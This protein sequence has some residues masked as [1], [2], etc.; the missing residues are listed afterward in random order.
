MVNYRMI[1][2]MIIKMYN[3]LK[4]KSMK[5]NKNISMGIILVFCFALGIT[6]CKEDSDLELPRLFRPIN[7]NVETNKTVATITWA[8]VDD[9]VSYT[10]Q[11]STDSVN[12][13]ANIV[14]DTTL[15]ELSFVKELAGE[16]N[17]YARLYANASDAA[18]NSKYNS[19]SFKTPAENIFTGYGTDIN[20]GKL[21]SAYMTD[22]HTLTIKWVPAAN[23][24][25]LIL[26]SADEATRDSLVI[27]GS[28]ALAGEKVVSSLDNSKWSVKIYNNKILRGT[29]T[30][31]I[32]GDVIVA[33]TD[34][35]PTAIT[36]AIDGQ[37]LLLAKGALYQMGSATFRLGK[38]VKVRG[39]SANNRPVLAMTSGTPT[40]TSSMLGFVDGSLIDYVKFENIDFTG[41]CDNSNSATK[42]GYL[43]NNNVLTTVKNLTFTNCNLHNFGNTPMRVQASKNQVIDTLSFNGCT[44]F[45]VGFS[46]TYA[47]VNSN[48]ADFINNINFSY[49]TIYN[50]KGSLVLRQNQSFNAINITNCTINQGMQDTGSTRFLIDAN[51]ATVNG[52]GVTIK[53]CIL[54]QT[55]SVEKGAAGIRTTGTV[56]IS[57]TYCTKDYFDETLVGGAA[58]SVKDKMTLFSGNSTDLWNAPTTGD[59]TL[60]ASAFA[61][62][63]TVGDLRWY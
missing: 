26:T 49:C 24:T 4:E 16:T 23:V 41:Y 46:S 52:T 25:H 56:S 57:T 2:D 47:I 1:M 40:T 9:A 30:G 44:I 58:F 53:N 19:L 14:L 13:D 60:K 48:S 43:F 51:T 61:G 62:K 12:Y 35:L 54:G 55:G 38:N 37:V 36:N 11:L 3:T 29:T 50:F 59:F 18:K 42:I 34:D 22:V 8:K 7:F 17:Y 10:L 6:S 63:G 32:E 27:S 15:T 28:E 39:L 5:K 20:T 33:A 45:D 31:I 21:Y